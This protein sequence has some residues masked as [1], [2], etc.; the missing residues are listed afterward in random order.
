MNKIL[1]FDTESTGIPDWKQ[2]SDAEHQPHLVQLAGIL[3]DADSRKEIKT[4]DVIIRPDGWTIPD[5]V[6]EIH[7]ITTERAMDEG[8]P[9]PEALEQFL[10]LYRECSLRVAH[11]TTFDN[12][13]IRIALKRYYPELISDEEWKDRSRY[14]C[15]YLNAKKLMGG[16][17]GHTLAEVYEHF[18][19]KPL[20]GAHQAMTDTRACMAVYWALRDYQAKAA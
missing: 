8:I 12:R 7:G 3:A 4:L 15:T 1:A 19:G 9:E 14:Y 16:C 13:M 18:I 11:N 2:P 5:D 6:A 20:E 10:E 17:D